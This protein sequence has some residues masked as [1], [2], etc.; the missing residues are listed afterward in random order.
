MSLGE[1]DI[2]RFG[3]AVTEERLTALL[4][5]VD[6]VRAVGD[7]EPLHRMRVASRRLR[8]ALRLFKECFKGKEGKRW[9]EEAKR[10]TASL[11]EARD[12]DVQI[13]FLTD[14]DASWGSDE[15]RP[16]VDHLRCRREELQPGIIELM[17]RLARDS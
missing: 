15:L 17:D 12:L 8:S 11:G 13:A 7:I 1:K 9:R 16:L 5:E 3:R 14:M 2:C 6:G 10:V 4:A